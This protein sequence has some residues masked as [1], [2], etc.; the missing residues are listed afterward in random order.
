MNLHKKVEG[1][2]Y[3]YKNIKV[4][5]ESIEIEIQDIKA[6]YAGVS[7]ISYEE[8]TGA[9]NKF[10]SS[11][12]NEIINKEHLISKLTLELNKKKALIRKIDNAL[13]ALNYT[14]RKIIELKCFDKLQYKQIANNLSIDNNYASEVKKKAIEIM[15]PLICVKEIYISKLNKL[16]FNPILTQF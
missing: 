2:L 12:E 15:I 16:N 14:Q 10:N 9:T 13:N 6:E 7:G 1:I 3:N 8:K 4:E 11:V 5:I